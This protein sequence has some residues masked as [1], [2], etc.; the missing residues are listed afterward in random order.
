MRI[1]HETIYSYLYVLPRGAL[2][3]ELIACL[4][5]PRPQRRPRSRDAERRGKIPLRR[6]GPR[7][8]CLVFLVGELGGRSKAHLNS[9]SPS[10][11]TAGSNRRAP[12]DRH[13]ARRATID[14]SRAD[15]SPP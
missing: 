9:L 4:R 2:R 14:E 15:V 3:K 13:L 8:P 7:P 10:A 11:S 1:S 12:L 6:P 5:Q